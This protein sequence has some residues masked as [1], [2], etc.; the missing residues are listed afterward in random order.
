MNHDITGLAAVRRELGLSGQFTAWLERIRDQP[1]VASP[2][3][4][5]DV[6]AAELLDQLGVDPRDRASTLAARPDPTSQPALWWIFERVFHDV[7]AT[8]GIPPEWGGWPSLPSRTGSFGRHLYVW[9]C[10]ALT[11]H[12]REYHRS[13]GIP[14]SLSWTALADLGREMRKERQLSG[15]GGLDASWGLPR[16]FRGTSYRL[17]RLVFERGRPEELPHPFLRT[18]EISLGT[19]IPD[20]GRSLD[21]ASCD[22]SLIAAAEFFP[23]HFGEQPTAFNCHSWLMD[24]QLRQYLPADSNIIRFHSRFTF[25]NDA[26]SGDHELIE[27]IFGRTYDG[28]RPPAR[29]LAELPQDTRLQRAIVTHLRAGRHW[30]NRTGW[31]RAE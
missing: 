15:L 23:R 29:L 9:L 2:V 27:H 30:V 13:R 5:P 28:L 10:V 1:T 7:V 6:E 21:P 24:D 8:M 4:P 20:T 22:E 26:E 18:G 25:F 11:P 31:M 16:T 3:I 17:G 14:D 12:V 19:H